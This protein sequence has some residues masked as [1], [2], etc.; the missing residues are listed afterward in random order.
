M[1][2]GMVAPVG[3]G[4]VGPIRPGEEIDAPSLGKFLSG[5]LPGF[6]PRSEIEI[7]QFTGGHSNL[8]YLLK[9]G[10][11]EYVLRRPPMGPVPPKAHDMAREFRVLAAVHPVF[12][13]APRV[14]V[15]CED[16]SVIGAMFFVMERRRGVVPSG[17][18]SPEIAERIGQ[19]FIDCLSQMHGI[20]ADELGIGKPE[21]FLARQV[22][23]W[24]ERW[25][26]AR[27]EDVPEM[28]RVVAWLSAQMPESAGPP[29][30]VHNDYKLDN[31]L[32]D[33]LNPGRVT[34]VLDWEMSTVGDPLVDV[35]CTLAYWS[36]L[37]AGGG[38]YTRERFLQRYAATTGRDVSGIRY[39]EVFGLFKLAVILQQIYFRFLRGQTRDPRFADFNGR[40]RVLAAAAAEKTCEPSI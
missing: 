14:F 28:E 4:E 27:T 18:S 20:R 22:S 31:V 39:Y 5:K 7:R 36:Q 15:L 35:G 13:P 8:T 34:A 32:L 23:G 40:V 19:S 17:V 3:S 11:Y 38:G 37:N 24:S 10:G 9:S 6:E 1:V 12:P 16:P 33:E 26:H 25:R 30:L 29:S 21:G 2:S